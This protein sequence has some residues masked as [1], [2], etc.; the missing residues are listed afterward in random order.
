MVIVKIETYMNH[1]KLMEIE[2]I[3]Q[4][5]LS[6]LSYQTSYFE[7]EVNLIKDGTFHGLSRFTIFQIKFLELHSDIST[8]TP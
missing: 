8:T 4:I 7:T 2:L 3:I 5:I 6:F 1:F